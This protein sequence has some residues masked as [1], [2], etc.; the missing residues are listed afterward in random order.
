MCQL[1]TH[2]LRTPK[3]R[4]LL[5]CEPGNCGNGIWELLLRLAWLCHPSQPLPMQCQA[6]LCW[7]LG[8]AWPVLG[9]SSQLP[10]LN[11]QSVIGFRVGESHSMICP[12][13]LTMVPG[14]KVFSGAPGLLPGQPAAQTVLP[15]LKLP[16]RHKGSM[17]S[18]CSQ[19][20]PSMA[21]HE[22]CPRR[23]FMLGREKTHGFLS[24]FIEMKAIFVKQHSTKL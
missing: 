6:W 4:G 8:C 2:T 14:I 5:G 16:C 24:R 17:H 3:P 23:R 10:E 22:Y 11:T 20:P 19:H 1:S 13:F 15:Q 18:T 21:V 12:K 7:V 9:A